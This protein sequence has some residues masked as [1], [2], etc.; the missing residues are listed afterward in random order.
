SI[1]KLIPNPPGKIMN[2]RILFD[3]PQFKE[4]IDL[5]ATS[6]KKLCNIRGNEISMIF[7]EPMTSM[8][9]VYTCGDQVTESL[10]LFKKLSKKDAK[11]K[12][13][14]LFREV[15][16]PRPEEIFNSYPHQISG[17]QKQRVMIA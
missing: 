2:G 13:I 6:D 10:M 1:I 11:L 9:P 17:G 16:L 7:Q 5:L 12:T 3:S 14:E 15:D 4:R 8:N